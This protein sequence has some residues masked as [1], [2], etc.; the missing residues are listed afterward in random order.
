MPPA[1]HS[2]PAGNSG[3]P[4]QNGTLKGKTLLATT[5]LLLADFTLTVCSPYKSAFIADPLNTF[6]V[7]TL[8]RCKHFLNRPKLSLFAP[9]MGHNGTASG[10]KRHVMPHHLPMLL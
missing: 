3:N 5:Q 4:G 6:V 7:S 2:V 1:Y 9:C 10:K 8:K